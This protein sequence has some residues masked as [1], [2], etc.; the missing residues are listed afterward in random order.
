MV[1][2]NYHQKPGTEDV[3]VILFYHCD[4]GTLVVSQ[5]AE[6]FRRI[7]TRTGCVA[8]VVVVVV[9]GGGGGGHGGIEHNPV[10]RRSIIVVVSGG[11]I[12]LLA[13]AAAAAAAAAV[14]FVHL[15]FFRSVHASRKE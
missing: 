4:S 14:G 7:R 1:K 10:S 13:A 2:N 6:L 15:F 12:Q 5:P 9:G 3:P 8:V 11:M